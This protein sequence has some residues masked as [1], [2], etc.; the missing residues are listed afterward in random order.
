MPAIA[1]GHARR[2]TGTPVMDA[3]G[4]DFDASAGRSAFPSPGRLIYQQRTPMRSWPLIDELLRDG[5]VTIIVDVT[6]PWTLTGHG[7]RG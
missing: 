3:S 6:A 4:R 5:E 2:D 7:A 1:P